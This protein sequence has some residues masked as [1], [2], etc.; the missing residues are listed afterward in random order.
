M[1]KG[2]VEQRRPGRFLLVSDLLTP[3]WNLRD[4][5]IP[6]KGVV[7]GID[8]FSFLLIFL[9]RQGLALIVVNDINI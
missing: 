7:E 8:S 2:D 3:E 4:A 5:S 6:F 9:F 1:S